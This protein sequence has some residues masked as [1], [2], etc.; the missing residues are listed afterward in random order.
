MSWSQELTPQN[1]IDTELRNRDLGQEGT[2][3]KTLKM[4]QSLPQLRAWQLV[5]V[6]G[7][8]EL[9]V[10]PCKYFMSPI[11]GKFSAPLVCVLCVSGAVPEGS[12]WSPSGI[13]WAEQ[14]SLIKHEEPVFNSCKGRRGRKTRHQLSLCQ[15][16]CCTLFSQRSCGKEKV[17]CY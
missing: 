6:G 13:T 14:E 2:P 10:F 3:T 12:C 11:P 5:P 16:H 7:I 17:I 8:P 1:S 9:N 4:P 15:F